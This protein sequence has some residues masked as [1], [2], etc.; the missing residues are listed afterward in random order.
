MA[1]LSREKADA[2]KIIDDSKKA[3][4]SIGS[5]QDFEL[6]DKSKEALKKDNTYIVVCGECSVGKSSLL[7]EYINEEGF[8]PI[9]A[10]VSTNCITFI[11]Y[12]K[13]EKI[14]V[15]TKSQEGKFKE[16]TISRE[17]I[18]DYVTEQGNKSNQKNVS[19]IKI[20]TPNESLK[21]GLV[22]VDTPGV[23]GLDK[24]HSEVTASFIPSADAVIYASTATKPLD[25]YELEFIKSKIARYCDNVVFTLTKADKASADDKEAIIKTNQ[26][27]ISEYTGWNNEEVKIVPISSLAM[28]AYR[29]RGKK[30]F[31]ASSNF[32]ELDNQI[33]QSYTNRKITKTILPNIENVKS[34]LIDNYKVQ[35]QKYNALL[36]GQEEI[37]ELRSKLKEANVNRRELLKKNQTWRSILSRGTKNMVSDLN[38]QA[39]MQLAEISA[40]V[41]EDTNVNMIIGNEEQANA[42]IKD[43]HKLLGDAG[44]KLQQS[45]DLFIS[46]II[47]DIGNNLSES[48]ALIQNKSD[49]AFADQAFNKNKMVG[50]KEM[51]VNVLRAGS[52]GLGTAGFAGTAV[53]ALVGGIAWPVTL[54]MVAIGGLSILFGAKRSIVDAKHKNNSMVCSKATKCIQEAR[55]IFNEFINSARNDLEEYCINEVE[56]RI[57]SQ[58]DK[59]EA[60][61]NDIPD[62]ITENQEKLKVAL[63][64]A[65]TNVDTLNKHISKSNSIINS[66]KALSDKLEK[67]NEQ[68]LN[69]YRK[70]ISGYTLSVVDADNGTGQNS[71][72]DEDIHDQPLQADT[73]TERRSNLDKDKHAQKNQEEDKDTEFDVDALF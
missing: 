9:D 49:F 40:K 37:K 47:E 53:A 63:G 2:I 16:K 25:T 19:T 45:C 54:A 59:Y 48:I 64:E 17:E 70:M 72:F 73:N 60:L 4:E 56:K 30:A 18:S 26:E 12:G 5:K 50:N 28:Q 44:A 69:K 24:D 32:E 21:N 34:I 31:L 7:T 33:I 11:K 55:S 41:D 43:I 57:N 51:F 23:G 3:I 35:A 38:K 65:K 66:Y 68:K 20:E 27:K 36:K 22:L 39:R 29:K 67:Q 10:D 14:T 13:K 46:E 8:F 58:I 62:K 42:Y 52:I 1:V 6:L 71:N 15:V 61:I